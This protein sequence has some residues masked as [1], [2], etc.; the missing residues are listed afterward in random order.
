MR[1]NELYHYGV[2]GMKWGVR[3]YQPYKPGERNGLFKDIKTYRV[4]KKRIKN[5]KRE[6][7]KTI[8]N[9]YDYKI[10][11]IEK[12]YKRGETLSVRDQERERLAGN[13][14]TKD[15]KNSDKKYKS[16]MANLKKSKEYQRMIKTAKIGAVV[17]GALLIAGVGA[18]AVY[19]ISKSN[20]TKFDL[21]GKDATSKAMKWYADA[22]SAPL[23][24]L[25][26]EVNEYAKDFKTKGD[27]FKS[28]ADQNYAMRDSTLYGR[29][30]K[31]GYMND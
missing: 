18:Y 3:R 5:A 16:D 9:R 22:M 17:A 10:N 11:R 26:G 7:N 24:S 19:K 20:Y 1:N 8:Q 2:P 30:H 6:R 27:F 13:K 14:A 31:K 23:N 21:A 28:I 12:S 25:T 4:N 29:F 15:W